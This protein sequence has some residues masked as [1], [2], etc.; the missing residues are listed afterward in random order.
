M[1]WLK[2]EIEHRKQNEEQLRRDFDRIL[3]DTETDRKYFATELAK[4]EILLETLKETQNSL[5]HFQSN[6]ENP[7]KEVKKNLSKKKKTKFSFENF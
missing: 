4:R 1:S 3:L 6:V 7:T 2:Q 5:N